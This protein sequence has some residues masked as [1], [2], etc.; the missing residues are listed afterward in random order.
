MGLAFIGIEEFL[1]KALEKYKNFENKKKNDE[2][3][4]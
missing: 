2:E 1:N 4:K 3:Y